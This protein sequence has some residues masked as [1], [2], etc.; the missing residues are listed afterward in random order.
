[1]QAIQSPKRKTLGLP[2]LY[3]PDGKDWDFPCCCVSFLWG[4]I[5]VRSRRG[6]NDGP[7]AGQGAKA[8]SAP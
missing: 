8:T 1:M 5:K 4:R 7:M 2:R 6:W 3:V